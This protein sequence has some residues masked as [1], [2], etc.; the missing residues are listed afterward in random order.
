MPRPP[1]F[2]RVM[3][4]PRF[5]NFG[6][7]ELDS[8]DKD[9]I[10]MNIEEVESIRLMDLEGLDQ[11]QCA[12]VMGIARSTFQRIYS[13]AKQK[14]ADS[15][16]NGKR[17]KI[18]GG[19]YTLNKCKITCENCGHEWEESTD[20]LNNITV[21]C[22]SCGS[23]VNSSCDNDMVMCRHCRRRNRNGQRFR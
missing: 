10:Y 11:I 5:R 2:R 19:N 6:P 17:L 9:I 13:S 22:P 23:K 18:E 16:I 3:Y 8:N 15:L 7:L 4:L 21:I 14:V 1:K 12:E 20:N